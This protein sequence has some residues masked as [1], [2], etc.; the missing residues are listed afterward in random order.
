MTQAEHKEHEEH[1]AGGQTS[2]KRKKKGLAREGRHGGAVDG[3]WTDSALSTRPPH[4]T[5]AQGRCAE[6]SP[7]RTEKLSARLGLR[8]QG[9][10]APSPPLLFEPEGR[11]ITK[12]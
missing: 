8:V 1:K 4:D 10:S 5:C 3:V 11:R 7:K 2:E 6:K 12:G 9:F